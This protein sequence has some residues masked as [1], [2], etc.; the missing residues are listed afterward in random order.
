MKDMC[1]VSC[2]ERARDVRVGELRATDRISHIH[3]KP[4]ANEKARDMAR[5]FQRASQ[6]RKGN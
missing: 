6:K 2:E 3:G 5:R 1:I 4:K